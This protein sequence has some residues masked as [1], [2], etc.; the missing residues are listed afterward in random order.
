[1]F[2]CHVPR[3]IFKIVFRRA[4][5][6]KLVAMNIAVL[7][8]LN[9]YFHV[10]EFGNYISRAPYCCSDLPFMDMNIF[11]V[12]ELTFMLGLLMYDV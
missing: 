5:N 3:K 10:D 9:M 6:K 8:D 7:Y 4:L 2:Y 1:M 12:I 11:I